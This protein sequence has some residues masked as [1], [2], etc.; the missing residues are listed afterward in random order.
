MNLSIRSEEKLVGGPRKLRLLDLRS[1]IPARIYLGAGIA[2]F[3]LVFLLWLLMTSFKLVSPLF[4]PGPGAVW[5]EFLRQC[6]EGVL[7]QDAGASLYRISLGW[8][9]STLVAVPIGIMMGNFKL[10]EGM[11]EPFID[12]VRYMPAVAFVPLTILWSGVGDTQKILILFIGTFFQEVLMIMDNVKS[13]PRELIE[14]S[15]TFG[16]S[17]REILTDV[18]LRYAMPG[19]WDTFRITLGWAWTYLVVAELVAANVGL[20]YRIMRAQRFLQTDSIIL[21]IIV[22]GLMGLIT[23]TLFKLA[24]KRMFRWMDRKG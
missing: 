13:V 15:Q 7:V 12:L 18:I 23:D 1:E 21:G 5:Q 24:Y 20:G 14:V 8:L 17:R 4:L 11:W 3:A 2:F 9:I 19:I 22:I 6:R 10:F 16:L